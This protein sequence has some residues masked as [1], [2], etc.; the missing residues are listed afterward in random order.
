MLKPTT[1]REAG[2]G[3][4]DFDDPSRYD[5]LTQI[6]LR[7]PEEIARQAAQRTPFSGLAA[8]EQ[9]F[10]IAADH[11]AR[12]AASVGTQL[13]V[14]ADRRVLLDRLLIALANPGC[15]G[16]LASP[17]I[18]DDLQLLGA[19][20]GKLVIGSLNR[21]GIMGA[22][23]EVDDLRTGHSARGAVQNNLDGV[24]ALCRICLDDAAT[25][26]MLEAMAGL[27]DDLAEHQRIAMLEPFMSEWREGK[28]V[29]QLD[30]DSVIKSIQIASA[31][32]NT[33]AYTWLKI[34][35][36]NEMER[37]MA[38]TTLPSLLLGGDTGD[39][40]ET[41]L[42]GWESALALPNVV[43][44]TA[45]RRLLYPENGDVAAAVQGAVDVLQVSA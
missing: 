1:V 19:L 11:T 14:M 43:G 45:G 22:S 33:T 3:S 21:A 8:G 5:E 39:D 4:V 16:V 13:G 2:W 28:L 40:L 7:H 15:R 32:G 23:F 10:V 29:N 25:P 20:D 31:L 24:K 18:L 42:R 12:G 9:L 38:S 26:R 35:Y 41:L 27:V 6:R 36:V 17:D 44:L 37:V 34:P 30:P